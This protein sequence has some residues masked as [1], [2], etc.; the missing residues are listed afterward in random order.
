MIMSM[1][2][3]R[4]VPS[5]LGSIWFDSEEEETAPGSVYLSKWLF[6]MGIEVRWQD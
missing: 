1:R 6:L 4:S 2:R 3:G 5:F